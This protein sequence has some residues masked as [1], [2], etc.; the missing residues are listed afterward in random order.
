MALNRNIVIKFHKQ[1]ESNSSI[2]KRLIMN[3][4]TVWKIVKNLRRLGQ[5]WINQEVVVNELFVP[6]IWLKTRERSCVV[7]RVDLIENWLL[8]QM[9]AI[10]RCIEWWKMILVR[11]PKKFFIVMNSQNT[12]RKWEWKEVVKFGWDRSRH[13]PQL[14]VH[15]WEKIWHI[16]G[17]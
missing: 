13:A 2:A 3:R 4:T 8:K 15:G 9:W 14:S 16:A 7:I 10:R 11:N 12:I 17:C 5:H 1:G 6:W